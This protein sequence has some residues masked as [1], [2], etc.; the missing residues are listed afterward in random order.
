MLH[1]STFYVDCFLCY[2]IVLNFI[3]YMQISQRGGKLSNSF[4]I[5]RGRIGKLS[6]N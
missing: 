6:A 2:Y 3:F 1:Y 4:N 5:G